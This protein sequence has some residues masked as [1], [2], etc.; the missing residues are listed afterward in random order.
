MIV[1]T[2]IRSCSGCVA[3]VWRRQCE[4]RRSEYGRNVGGSRRCIE[5]RGVGQRRSIVK[6]GAD[7]Q[8]RH[9]LVGRIRNAFRTRDVRFAGMLRVAGR[10]WRRRRYYGLVASLRIVNGSNY[11]CGD[12][13]RG[14]ILLLRVLL[15]RTRAQGGSG[16]REWAGSVRR[17]CNILRNC[18][19]RRDRRSA[20]RTRRITADDR[21]IRLHVD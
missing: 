8:R 6:L 16:P 2:H 20:S 12:I 19:R 4:G 1:L 17:L 9:N 21:G 7:I 3:A 5:G 10:R 14:D 13:G 18:V 11:G 15:G